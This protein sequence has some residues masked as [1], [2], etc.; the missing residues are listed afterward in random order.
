MPVSYT[1]L[2]RQRT[3]RSKDLNVLAFTCEK[4]ECCASGS[5]THEREDDNGGRRADARL[6]HVKILEQVQYS[7]LPLPACCLGKSSVGTK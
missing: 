1:S 7:P 5:D 3:R 6:G 4:W 2:Y